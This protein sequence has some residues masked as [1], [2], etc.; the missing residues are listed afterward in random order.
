MKQTPCDSVLDSYRFILLV[1]LSTLA[2]KFHSCK[3]AKHPSIPN[4][5]YTLSHCKASRFKSTLIQL[6]YCHASRFQF[7][8]TMDQWLIVYIKTP[9]HHRLCIVASDQI[10]RK[11]REQAKWVQNLFVCT[12][13]SMVRLFTVQVQRQFSVLT[14]QNCYCWIQ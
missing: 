5:I 8:W 7:A 14:R 4:H 2:D 1:W 3:R 11:Q 9:Y 6:C 12:F 10:A 13:I